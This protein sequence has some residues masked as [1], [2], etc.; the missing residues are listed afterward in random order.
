[1]GGSK[2]ILDKAQKDFEQ[3]DY[4]FAATAVNKVVQVEPDNLKARA[5]LADA[6]EQMGYQAEGRVPLHTLR[7]DI[8][9]GFIEARTTYGIIGVK[10]FIF[11]G[12]ILKKDHLQTESA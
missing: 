1:M 11:K 3:G 7:A 2:N 9:Y 8:D 12:E 5:L 6:Y 10:V 4:R